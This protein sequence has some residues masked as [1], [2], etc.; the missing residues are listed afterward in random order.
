MPTIKSF[1]IVCRHPPYGQSL[2]RD[3]LDMA[4]ATAAFDQKIALLFLG[5]GVLQLIDAQNGGAIGQKSHAKQLSALP[6]YDVDALYVDARSLGERGLD[7]AD[8]VLPVQLLSDTEIASLY[9]A[10]DIVLGF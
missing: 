1:L 9:A 8:L 4:L 6:L 5:D 3:A 7:S 10:H 2:A